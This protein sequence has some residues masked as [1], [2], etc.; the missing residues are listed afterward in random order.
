MARTFVPRFSTQLVITPRLWISLPS[1][2][3]STLFTASTTACRSRKRETS[4]STMMK[5]K[6]FWR[7]MNERKN[8]NIHRRFVVNRSRSRSHWMRRGTAKGCHVAGEN[9]CGAP[10]VRT[11]SSNAAIKFRLFREYDLTSPRHAA[12][13]VNG[14]LV[15]RPIHKTER[16]V[17]GKSL[18]S[19]H[20]QKLN[21]PNC[22]IFAQCVMQ[23]S[24]GQY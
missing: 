8:L 14:T 22:K 13:N 7:K 20:F 5:N 2:L 24:Q 4:T 10:R 21:E 18:N 6:K 17:S 12:S 19:G 11:V 15:W 9:V 3:A 23:G 16:S 1:S